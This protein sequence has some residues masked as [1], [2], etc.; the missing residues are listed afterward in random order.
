MKNM[1]QYINDKI[2]TEWRIGMKVIEKYSEEINKAKEEGRNI[3][4]CMCNI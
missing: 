4:A 3:I 2:I 1:I